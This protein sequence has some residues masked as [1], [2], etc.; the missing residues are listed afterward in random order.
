MKLR[1]LISAG[2][3][4]V[5]IV[6]LLWLASRNP[7]RSSGTVA[8]AK[9][10]NNS[11]SRSQDASNHRLTKSEEDRLLLGDIAKVPFQELFS[12]LAKRTPEENARLAEQLQNLPHSSAADGQI[13]AFYKAW[14]TSDAKAALTSAIAMRDARFREKA[15]SAVVRAA[16]PTAAAAL[17]QSIKDL[18]A[19]AL[20]AS[21][22]NWILSS[23]IGKWAE[24]EPVA[25]AQFLDSIGAQG[26]DFTAA[27]NSTSYQWSLQDPVAALAWARQHP[28]GH[29]DLALQGAINGWWEKDPKAA[30]AYVSAQKDAS[31]HEMMVSAFA[32]MLFDKDPEHARQWASQL[33]DV[34][35][36]R[37]ADNSVAQN[38][39][40]D[41]PEAATRWAANLPADERGSAV[42]FAAYFWAKEDPKTAGDFLNSLAGSARDE[43][44]VTFSGGVAI[45]DSALALTWAA[46]ISDPSIRQK[47]EEAIATEW[48]KQDP[49]AARAWIQNSS[50]PEA[51]KAR[52]LGVNPG[53]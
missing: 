3:L 4:A 31:G 52:L 9:T 26:L 22:K 48:L 47:S 24:L 23:A 14:A 13:A 46:T 51:E 10:A 28:D 18:P 41:D 29:G 12:L 21:R 7:A 15:I 32:N 50:M 43:A 34:A 49:P 16:D 42:G 45:E 44:V 38:W 40:Q 6:G 30:E 53:P 33:P 35:A 1:W 2:V 8:G 17:A 20:P 39:A 25:A 5:V 27:F 37:A 19:S 11:R 36:R